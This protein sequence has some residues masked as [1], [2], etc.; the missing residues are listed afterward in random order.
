MDQTWDLVLGWPWSERP[1]ERTRYRSCESDEWTMSGGCEMN[2]S[3]DMGGSRG[4]NWG[5][6]YLLPHNWY[7]LMCVG[8]IN[9]YLHM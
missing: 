5:Y 7:S 2:F 6:G 3:M 4:G 8:I 1:S 9:V